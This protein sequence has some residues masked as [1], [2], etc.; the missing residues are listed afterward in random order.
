METQQKQ[1]SFPGPKS[2]QDFR[3][4]GRA[5]GELLHENMTW[6]LHDQMLLDN[7]MIL[8][9]QKIEPWTR[10]TKNQNEM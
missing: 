10:R 6:N 9:I 8:C 2:Y 1:N 3:E 7:Y 4:T 5:P